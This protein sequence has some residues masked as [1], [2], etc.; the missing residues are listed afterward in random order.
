MD[1][2]TLKLGS[3]RASRSLTQC[4]IKAARGAA[5]PPNAGLKFDYRIDL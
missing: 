5:F 3:E 1:R 4:V 2:E